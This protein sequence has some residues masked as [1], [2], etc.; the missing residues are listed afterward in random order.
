MGDTLGDNME[1]Y[2][3]DDG[4]K[5]SSLV[6]TGEFLEC[7]E[8]LKQEISEE[9]KDSN[10]DQLNIVPEEVTI[11]PEI[12]N[13]IGKKIRTWKGWCARIEMVSLN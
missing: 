4:K 9:E 5:T 6:I 12:T 1:E 10:H 2:E 3:T 13:Y 8:A 7:N 11:T